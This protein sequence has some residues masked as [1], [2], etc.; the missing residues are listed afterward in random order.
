MRKALNLSK[1]SMSSTKKVVNMKCQE[2][3]WSLGIFLFAL[4]SVRFA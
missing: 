1:S 2:M 3:K 4:I